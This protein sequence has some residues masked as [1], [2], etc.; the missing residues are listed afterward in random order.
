MKRFMNNKSTVFVAITLLLI[1]STH[2]FIQVVNADATEQCGSNRF[3]SKVFNCSASIKKNPCGPTRAGECVND[4]CWC[5]PGFTNRNRE[6]ACEEAGGMGSKILSFCGLTMLLLAGKLTRVYVKP[7]HF[8]YLPSCVIGGI[9]GLLINQIAQGVNIDSYY[10]I[11]V[12]FTSGWESLPG[13]LINIVFASLFLGSPVPAVRKVWKQ[14]GPNL[15]YGMATAW[16]Q[17]F[18]GFFITLIFLK[19]VFHVNEYFAQTLPIGFAGGHGTAAALSDVFRDVGFENGSDI[20]LATA[21]VGLLSSVT[22]GIV[23]VNVASKKGWVKHSKML[24]GTSMLAKKGLTNPDKRPI[25]G[26]QTTS[27]DSIDTMAWH[28]VILGIA[29]FCG[30]CIK[31]I[32]KVI[33]KRFCTFPLFPLCMVAG[34]IMQLCLQKFDTRYKLVD[35]STMERIAGT[36]LDFLIVG[37]IAMV[38]AGKVAE[39]ILPFLIICMCGIGFEILCMMYLAPIMVPTHWFE[40][41]ICCYGQDTGVIAAG[42]M[43]LRMVDP[44]GKTPVPDAFGYKQPIHSA[45]MG[46]GV[47]TAI[48]IPVQQACNSLFLTTIVTLGGFL[49]VMVLWLILIY[50]N[51]GKMRDEIESK[52]NKDENGEEMR[53]SFGS[54]LLDEEDDE[55]D[56]RPLL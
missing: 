24:T 43:L 15:M 18:V 20:S 41:G 17:M 23:L 42:L 26:L 31:E 5:S 16:G 37:A 39:D 38:N 9:Y 29:C 32:L 51:L 25:A 6:N 7:L 27:G 19:P 2:N 33:S 53:H 52:M 4:R 3:T 45:L 47:I 44:E 28:L 35:R 13:F 30:W 10:W 49:G 8:L 22:V 46:G 48:W 34:L 14:S 50:P 56:N 54:Q 1:L 21:T 36:S 11:G 12:Y 55:N 40:N